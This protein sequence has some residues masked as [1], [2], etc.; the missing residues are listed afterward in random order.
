M[1]YGISTQDIALVLAGL[2]A[3][4]ITGFGGYKFGVIKISKEAN[5]ACLIPKLKEANTDAKK[6]AAKVSCD[7][8]YPIEGG[9]MLAKVA[10]FGGPIFVIVVFLAIVIFVLNGSG[11]AGYS[12]MG[13]GSGYGGSAYGSAYSSRGAF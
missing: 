12:S 11:G 9:D 5:T 4:G 1:S 6:T 7:R 10:L 2:M 8:T 3:A 13:G